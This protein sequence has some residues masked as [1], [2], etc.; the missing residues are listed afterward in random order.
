MFINDITNLSLS[1]MVVHNYILLIIFFIGF[2]AC[3]S[4]I[5]RRRKEQNK[6]IRKLQIER[7]LL[8]LAILFYLIIGIL[9]KKIL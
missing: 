6:S 5:F 2:F 3:L 8:L 1:I 9:T 7:D 4:S